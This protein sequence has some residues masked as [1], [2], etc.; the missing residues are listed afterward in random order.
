MLCNGTTCY[1]HNSART[2]RLETKAHLP[3]QL[4]VDDQF[5]SKWII[6]VRLLLKSPFSQKQVPSQIDSPEMILIKGCMQWKEPKLWGLG[7]NPAAVLRMCS[8]SPD[9]I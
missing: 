5:Q 7:N 2:Q 3:S 9:G 8:L 6:Y 1:I 4:N